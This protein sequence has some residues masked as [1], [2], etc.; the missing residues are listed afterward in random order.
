MSNFYLRKYD[1][2]L[3]YDY[4]ALRVHGK[5][6]GIAIFTE[7]WYGRRVERLYVKSDPKNGVQQSL[8]VNMYDA[9]ANWAGFDLFT[10]VFYNKQA[11][12]KV[13]AGR[14]IY[15]QLY[16]NANKNMIIYWGSLNKNASDS[17]SP[18]A[19][20]TSDRFQGVQKLKSM[21]A[22]PAGWPYGA[23]FYHDTLDK[24][25]G[26]Y[27][28]GWRELTT[29]ETGQEAWPVNSIFISI[30]NTNPATTLGYGTWVAFG[31]GQTLIAINAGD[32]D[33]DTAEKTGGAKTVSAIVGAHAAK[34]TDNGAD[35]VL[36]P[37]GSTGT[38]VAA[39]TH[40]HNITQYT[41]S[42]TASSV[43]QPYIVVYMWKRTA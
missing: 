20:M 42:I 2:G 18:D 30:S 40:N 4:I 35:S 5:L 26:L 36:H 21:T 15:I 27:K 1:Y 31:L 10:K 33:F 16:L 12:G 24:I 14:N 25:V 11:K 28:T 43:V 3:Y 6:K 34:N 23:A 7:H 9:V 13:T 38:H 29:K 19:Y 8:R 17:L 39:A 41:H 32:G 22:Y 37:S